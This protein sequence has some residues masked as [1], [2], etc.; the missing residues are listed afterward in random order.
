M[1]GLSA[2]F[3]NALMGLLRKNELI[4]FPEITVTLASFIRFWNLFPKFA[5]GRLTSITNYKGYE[6]ASPTAHD[7]PKPAFVPS[8]VDK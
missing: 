1:I 3:A 6:L 7:R 8:F 5:A 2:P 4:S